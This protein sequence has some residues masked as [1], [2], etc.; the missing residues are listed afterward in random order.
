MSSGHSM[1]ECQQNLRQKVC[2]GRQHAQQLKEH[3]VS[4]HC[5]VATIHTF[6]NKVTL[7]PWQ[8]ISSASW[9]LHMTHTQVT[10]QFWYK[11]RHT[12]KPFAD[13][14]I[15]AAAE[16]C[17]RPKARG[18]SASLSMADFQIN[19]INLLRRKGGE[20]VWGDDPKNMQSVMQ[21]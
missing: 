2:T 6:Q 13:F 21:G 17:N 19:H 7:N 12:T 3:P 18:T 11:A 20:Q 16:Q 4:C 15:T 10:R 5:G 8:S 14:L 9:L 1:R